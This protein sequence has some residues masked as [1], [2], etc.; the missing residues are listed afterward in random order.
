MSYRQLGILDQAWAR[1]RTGSPGLGGTPRLVF[2]SQNHLSWQ[3]F[4]DLCAPWVTGQ[5]VNSGCQGVGLAVLKRAKSAP[6]L[7]RL[8]TSLSNHRAKVP[9]LGPRVRWRLN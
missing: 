5:M 8:P 7:R 2:N 4:S 6:S 1:G 3:K 9:G